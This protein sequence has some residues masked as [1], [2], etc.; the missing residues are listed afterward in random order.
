MSRPDR[1]FLPV[2]G[3]QQ[4][5][6]YPSQD[7]TDTVYYRH[8]PLAI[9]AFA[10]ILIKSVDQKNPNEHI[11]GEGDPYLLRWHLRRDRVNGNEYLHHMR[12]NDDD[13]A[14]H[15][16]P[17]DNTSIILSGC[18]EEVMAGDRF[19]GQETYQRGQSRFLYPGMI[20]TR[21]AEDAHL[22]RIV[23]DEPVWTLF[24]TGKN[25]RSWGFHTKDGWV[26]WLD[27]PDP[28][29]GITPREKRRQKARAAAGEI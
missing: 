13:R 21:K 7:G 3:V 19:P 20:V 25:V 9:K 5:R 6:P 24:I 12:R 18:V 8:N 16:H 2:Q 10:D 27:F 29:S 26:H 23:G 28:I 17:W 22:L 14:L 11:G 15:D 1:L 4:G